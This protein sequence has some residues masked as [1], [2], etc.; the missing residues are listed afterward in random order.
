[1]IAIETMTLSVFYCLWYGCHLGVVLL[2]AFNG[3]G[4]S[5]PV[6]SAEKYPRR[7]PLG[8]DL[9]EGPLHWRTHD[10]EARG[11][12]TQLLSTLNLTEQQGPHRTRPRAAPEETADYMLELYNQFSYDF[13][14]VPSASVVRSF[15]NQGT[16]FCWSK[17]GIDVV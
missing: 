10:L 11:L 17:S 3:L 14:A 2:E 12:L 16:A 6:I 5:S 4:V 1:M 15:R 9:H 8:R 13:S 7:S